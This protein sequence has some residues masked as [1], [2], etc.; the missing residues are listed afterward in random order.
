MKISS[1]RY[2]ITVAK[3]ESFT[4]AA[5][6]LFVSQ[7]TLSR[8]I[9]ELEEELGSQLFIRER[10]SLKLTVAGAG[11][12]LLPEAVEIVER[13]DRLPELLGKT[14][15]NE[16]KAVQ[17][18]KIA[19]QRYFNIQWL[20]P[21]LNTFMKEQENCEI[22][23]EQADVPDLKKGIENGRYDAGFGLMPF[24]ERIKDLVIVSVEENSLQLLCR[25]NTGWPLGNRSVSLN[26][27]Q[28]IL[29]C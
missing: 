13:C 4:K 18:I 25:R 10:Q 8:T 2:F 11:A 28:R 16:R 15:R 5:D 3:Y 6:R 29:S 22:M 14:E 21:L 20:Y 23:L 9:Q 7:P 26:W 17:V 24:F 19:Y 12:R 1:L 27:N